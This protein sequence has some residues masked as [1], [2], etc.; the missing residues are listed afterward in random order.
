MVGSCLVGLLEIS[1]QAADG[2][3]RAHMTTFIS[4]HLHGP[5]FIETSPSCN[6]PVMVGRH[7]R[8]HVGP[9]ETFGLG[10]G[11]PVPRRRQARENDLPV[12][13][14]TGAREIDAAQ[15]LRYRV[16]FEE[17]KGRPSAAAKWRR[18]DFDVYDAVADHLIVLDAH[19]GSGDPAV[20]GACCVGA[21]RG[22][23]STASRHPVSAPRPRSISSRCF[24]AREKFSKSDAPASIRITVR[25]GPWTCSGKALPHTSM[26]STWI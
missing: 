23:W 16:F 15:A 3:F 19:R 4:A 5:F 7:S 24:A 20:V 9:Y 14:A 25:A 1:R 12:R 11:N 10:S 8:A 13:L 6:P 17:G 2:E 22:L 21:P 26:H 18:R